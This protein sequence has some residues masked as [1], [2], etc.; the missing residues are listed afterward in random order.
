MLLIDLAKN[1]DPNHIG[2]LVIENTCAPIS[3][4]KRP[5]SN[6]VKNPDLLVAD[7][8]NRNNIDLAQATVIY[9]YKIAALAFIGSK[10]KGIYIGGGGWK[11]PRLEVSRIKGNILAR[12]GAC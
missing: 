3:G 9:S 5:T 6:P 10:F 8:M 2:N 11:N 12:V 4:N 7:I 1:I